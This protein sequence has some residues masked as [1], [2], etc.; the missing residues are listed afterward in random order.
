MDAHLK[1]KNQAEQIKIL[2]VDDKEENHIALESMFE[3]DLY[4]FRKAYSGKDALKILLKEYDFALILMDVEMPEMNGFETASMIYAREKLAHI[5]IIFITANDYKND[6]N[7]FNGYKSGSI[8][9]VIKPVNYNLLKMKSQ[10][11]IELYKKNRQLLINKEKL[12]QINHNL[13]LQIKEKLKIEE[14]LRLKN[15][16]LSDAQILTHIGSWNWDLLS[17]KMTGSEELYRIYEL[18]EKNKEFSIEKELEKVHP[19]DLEMV[20]AN[21]ANSISSGSPFDIYFRYLSSNGE[22]KYINKKGKV[23]KNDRDEVIK[24]FGTSQDI[25]SLKKMEDQLKIFNLFEKMLN[26]I[27]IISEEKF[28]L[29]YAN[30]EAIRNLGYSLNKI[31]ELN[32]FDIVQLNEDSFWKLAAPLINAKKEK[33]IFF[34]NFKR[35]DGTVYPVEIHLQLIR[36]HESW[37]SFPSL[38]ENIFFAVILDLTNRKRT[39][40]EL[41]ESLS[42]KELLI[43][44]IHHRIKNNLQIVSSLLN[45]QKSFISNKETISII[46]ESRNRVHSMALLHEKL[47][48]SKDFNR[49]NFIDYI[50]ELALS[51]VNTYSGINKKIELEINSNVEHVN[52]DL[53]V[54]LGLMINEFVCNSIKH[55]FNEIPKGK[56]SIDFNKIEN[57]HLRLFV[58]DNGIG[59][60]Q[61]FDIENIET[62]G[63][64]LVKSLV[65]QING[66]LLIYN[67]GG[68]GFE[69]IFPA[70]PEV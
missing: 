13:E 22:I 29:L 16:Q 62:L 58:K 48:K 37:Q 9:Y 6:D 67:N 2:V 52:I 47:Y 44:E 43:K 17:N 1:I 56:I 27:F 40:Q 19:S 10:V 18:S 60:S 54:A 66:K 8:D 15:F 45:I 33:I 21:L 5:P 42:Q 24:I 46:D 28:K 7:I 35:A 50:N 34:N 53:G 59:L 31:K 49:I 26:G 38:P 11:L 65:G 3:N 20:Q 57:N 70:V 12:D 63:L 69:I 23:I 39:E 64:E 25:T 4:L 32:L 30:A 51:L 55:A 41:A 36:Q 68:A 14:E 61:N